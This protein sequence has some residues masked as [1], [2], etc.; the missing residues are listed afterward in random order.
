MGK[1]EWRRKDKRRVPASPYSPSFPLSASE[2]YTQL[3]LGLDDRNTSNVAAPWLPLRTFWVC[4]REGFR[5]GFRDLSER[6]FE[7]V[8][9]RRERE[10]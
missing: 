9:L 5:G 4:V 8:G 2:D 7:S 10:V 6:M 1:E 3:R